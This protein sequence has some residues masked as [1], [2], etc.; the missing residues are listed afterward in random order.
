MGRSLADASSEQEKLYDTGDNTFEDFPV[1]TKVKVITLFE[2]FMFFYGE[3]GKV[4][5]NKGTYLSICVEFDE[6]RHFK[7]G[8][9][10]TDWN[11]NPTSLCILDE[12]TK[13]IAKEQKRL[14]KMSDK[15][16]AQ[17]EEDN[18][19]SERFKLIDL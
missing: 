16:R 13:T 18:K 9:I 19:R 1:G 15:K 2:D 7:G 6:P 12:K 3:T 14:A 17:E 8:H 4:I 10:Q 11:F 5:R